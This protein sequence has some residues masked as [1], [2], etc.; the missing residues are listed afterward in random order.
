MT[1][2][3]LNRHIANYCVTRPEVVAVICTVET[4]KKRT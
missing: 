3:Q 1:T 2:D 4:T